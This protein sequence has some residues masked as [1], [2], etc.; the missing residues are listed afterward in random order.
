MPMLMHVPIAAAMFILVP[1]TMPAMAVVTF[2][3]VLGTALWLIVAAVA[4]ANRGAPLSS[5]VESEGRMARG[6]L[7]GVWPKTP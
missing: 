4:L 3:L 1:Q 6:T 7:A 2:D 5:N